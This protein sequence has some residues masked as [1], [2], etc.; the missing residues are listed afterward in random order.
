VITLYA[1]LYLLAVVAFVAA[2]LK[3]PTKVHL[4]WIGAALFALVPTI[5]T[6]RGL[7]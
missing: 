6:F 3:P 1:I 4:G 5:A 2:A 7:S